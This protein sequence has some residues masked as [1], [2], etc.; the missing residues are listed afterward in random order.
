MKFLLKGLIYIVLINFIF[1]VGF[2]GWF[3]LSTLKPAMSS[4]GI[5]ITDI[6]FHSDNISPEKLQTVDNYFSSHGKELGGQLANKI[7][8]F[9]TH[10]FVSK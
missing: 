2:V 6:L 3:T 5:S 4:A 9:Y 7:S 10:M 1:S 8:G